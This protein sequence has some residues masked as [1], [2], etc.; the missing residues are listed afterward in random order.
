MNA[1]TRRALI[2]ALLLAVILLIT[3]WLMGGFD[4]SR[5]AARPTPL[6]PSPTAEP[7]VPTALP[8]T[9]AAALL[10]PSN[11]PTAES[12]PTASATQRADQPSVATKPPPQRATALPTASASAAPA[13]EEQRTA[14]ITPY[15]DELLIGSDRARAGAA[16]ALGKLTDYDWGDTEPG[17]Y[18]NWKVDPQPSR[19]GRARFAQMVRVNEGGYYPALDVIRRAA[20]ANPGSLWLIGNEPDVKW[21]DNVT[22]ERYAA[23]YGELHAAIKAADPTAQVAIGGASQPTPL[24]MAY[25]DRV[26]AAYRAQFG[27]EMPVDVWNIHAFILREERGSWGID[28]PPGMDA[29]QGQLYE[30][31]DHNNMAIFRQQIIDFRRWMAERGLRDKPLIVSEYGI[32]MPAS[33]GFPPDVVSGFLVDTFDYF[34]T[35]RDPELGYPADDNRLVQAFNWYSIADTTYPTSNLFDPETHN[36]TPVGETFKAYVSGLR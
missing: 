13:V 28:I 6:K 10:R 27:A 29:D 26:L 12:R 14:A 36:I 35:A 11:T 19:V 31:V 16:L 24:R 17:W 30:I 4:D 20:Q 1:S 25:L 3:L 8:T 7:L 18:L 23:I 32:L 22:P 2:G 5:T 33:Y 21:Q 15:A 9:R 34:L